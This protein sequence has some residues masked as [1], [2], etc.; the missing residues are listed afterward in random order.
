MTSQPLRLH[1]ATHLPQGQDPLLVAMPNISIAANFN[2]VTFVNG[3]DQQISNFNIEYAVPINHG[4]AIDPTIYALAGASPW[5]HI[6][7]LLPGTYYAE[8]RAGWFR[9]FGAVAI[10]LQFSHSSADTFPV[11]D[12]YGY[13]ASLPSEPGVTFNPIGAE[14]HSQTAVC[15]RGFI[16]VSSYAGTVT[17]WTTLLN[18]SGANRTFNNTTNQGGAQLSI[19]RL[20]ASADSTPA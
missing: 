19:I 9:D 16:F 3:V 17:V 11:S 4:G 6:D 5:D 1:A 15:R 20:S 12:T 18:S 2:G 14:G 10:N 8:A 13:T 7:I